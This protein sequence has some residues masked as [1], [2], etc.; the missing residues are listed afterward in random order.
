M[1]VTGACRRAGHRAEILRRYLAGA[2]GARPHLGLGPS[3][4]LPE[5]RRI[6]PEHPVFRIHELQTGAPPSAE[7]R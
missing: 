1:V 2:P 4:L 3:S 6:T 5:F 7:G